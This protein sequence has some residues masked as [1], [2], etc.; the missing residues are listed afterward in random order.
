VSASRARLLSYGSAALLSAIVLFV[1]FVLRGFGPESTIRE[2]HLVGSRLNSY[3]PPTV[4]Y[5]PEL[6]RPREAALLR[7]ITVLGPNDGAYL[8]PLMDRVIREADYANARYQIVRLDYK[9]PS[10]AI[11]VER[12]D[13]PQDSKPSFFLW[14]VEL[15][16][17]AWRLN[18][19]RTLETFATLGG[20]IRA[21]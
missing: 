1:F 15:K 3:I 16:D 20:D 9:T 10:L 7:S 14:I 18:A 19:K 21:Y 17:G 11:V 5:N 4:K 2:L 13:L 6:L 8:G 12:Y